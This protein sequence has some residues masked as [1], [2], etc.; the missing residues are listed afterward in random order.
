MELEDPSI[1]FKP[2]ADK[3][4]LI[5][6]P[7]PV[8]LLTVEDASLPTASGLE[9]QL[10]DFY[11]RMLKFERDANSHDLIYHADNF[12]LRFQVIE[13]SP[14][15]DSLRPLMIEVPRLSEIEQQLIDRETEYTRQRGLSA[16]E[17]RLV[18]QDPAGNWIEI[19]EYRAI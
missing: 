13:K 2:I 9:V 7:L 19:V 4:P 11:V 15:R 1:E 6:E 3:R 5:P 16:G 14:E 18:L 12:S 8:R 10:D 17:E